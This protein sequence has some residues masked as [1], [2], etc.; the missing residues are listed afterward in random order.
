MGYFHTTRRRQSAVIGLTIG[1]ILLIMLVRLLDQPWRGI[2]DVGVVVGMIWGLTSLLIFSFL[3]LT[4][5]NF[6]HPP[7]LP[8]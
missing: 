2:I 4:Q 3:A 1:V 6:D 5:N 8:N 7:E